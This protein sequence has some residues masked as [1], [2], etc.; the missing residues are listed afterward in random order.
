MQPDLAGRRR[1]FPGWT[2]ECLTA[3][4]MRWPARLRSSAMPRTA[5]LSAENSDSVTVRSG[6]TAVV[7]RL[8][9]S[10]NVAP[11]S[12]HLPQNR[13]FLRC[14]NRTH[15]PNQIQILRPQM[16]SPDDTGA[17]GPDAPVEDVKVSNVARA[18][19]R[20]RAFPDDTGIAL[21]GDKPVACVGPILK[22]LDGHVIAGLRVRY[23]R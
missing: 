18:P 11:A 21:K 20:F 22:L 12:H 10:V 15:W 16:P 5:A 8:V 17:R 1:P 19:A 14:Q 9:D 7:V 3:S 13:S 4:V 2:G 6:S 23:G